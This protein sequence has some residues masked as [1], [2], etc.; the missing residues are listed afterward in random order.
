MV[1]LVTMTLSNDLYVPM[2]NFNRS[3]CTVFLFNYKGRHHAP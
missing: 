3:E 2:K 1:D